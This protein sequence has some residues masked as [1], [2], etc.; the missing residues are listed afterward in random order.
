ML[1]IER[2][3]S[4]D[5]V[6]LLGEEWETL[7]RASSVDS[8]FMTWAW[9]S[10]WL[11]TEGAGSDLEVHIGRDPDSGALVGVAPC[12]VAHGRRGGVPVRELGLLGSGVAAPD[13]LDFMTADTAPGAAVELWSSLERHRRWDLIGFDGVAAAGHLADLL[14]RRHSDA[15]TQQPCPMLPLE[16][17]WEAVETGMSSRLRNNLR[18]YGRKLDRDADVAVSLVADHDTLDDTF[19]ALVA[20]H[21]VVRTAKGDAGVFAS[22]DTEAFLR[23]AAHRM[24]DSGRLRMW[25][26]DADGTPIAVIL[27]F[28]TG[29]TVSFY[30]TGYDPEWGRYGP[31]RRIMAIAIRGAIDEGADTFDFLRGDEPYKAEWG[32]TTRF[33]LVIER[34]TSARGRAVWA[35]RSVAR[36]IRPDRSAA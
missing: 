9:I 10:S 31:G 21:Q 20:F 26:L 34:P 5:S 23:L 22:P 36:L 2:L 19:D 33:D 12:Y 35:A 11:E 28:R 16:G 14:L 6:L 1:A 29:D 13:H 25:R 3:T 8:P 15:A 27:C 18:R 17:G 30:T 4:R 7:R 32:T 24:L